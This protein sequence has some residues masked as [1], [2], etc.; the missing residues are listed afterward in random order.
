MANIHFSRLIMLIYC[1]L[2]KLLYRYWL[3]VL[4]AVVQRRM[5]P[6]CAARTFVC[7]RDAWVQLYSAFKSLWLSLSLSLTLSTYFFL[8]TFSVSFCLCVSFGS[9]C[10]SLSVSVCLS[11]SSSLSVSLSYIHFFL[12][13]PLPVT[14]LL[15]CYFYYCA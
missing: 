2:L 5:R 4:R 13:L 10:V 15:D 14:E 11:F 9:L 6:P 12:C 8:S 7:T 1:G 3:L